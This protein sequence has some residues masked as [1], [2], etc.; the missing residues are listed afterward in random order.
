[1]QDGEREA[2]APY[3]ALV[4][5]F[6]SGGI[7]GPAFEQRFLD[8]YK[9]DPYLWSEPVFAVLDGLFADVD[10]Y[11]ADDDLRDPEDLDEAGLR[12]AAGRALA[13]LRGL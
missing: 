8:R 10:S 1:M 3:D 6:V 5:D 11:V 7:D 12:E 4:A 2:L 9:A 13:A